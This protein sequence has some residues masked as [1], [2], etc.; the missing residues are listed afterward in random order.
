[1][2]HGSFSKSCAQLGHTAGGIIDA[3]VDAI[4][5]EQQ[6][7][8]AWGAIERIACG[9]GVLGDHLEQRSGHRLLQP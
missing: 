5:H 8:G 7:E 4:S 3:D 6:A 9:A 2:G 1:M